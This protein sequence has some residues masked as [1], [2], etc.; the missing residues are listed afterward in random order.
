MSWNTLTRRRFLKTARRPRHHG[1]APST[2]RVRA[3]GNQVLKVAPS[4]RTYLIRRFALG[5][6]D[7]ESCAVVGWA[8]TVKRATS[9]VGEGPATEIA[10]ESP[11]RIRFQLKQ[12]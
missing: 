5:S 4:N 2:G 8:L 12:V 7:D 1:L 11:T 3:V 10:A 6:V 9:G